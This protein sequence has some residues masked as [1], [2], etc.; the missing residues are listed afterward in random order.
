M[1]C[2][3]RDGAG[4]RVSGELIRDSVRELRDALL[5]GGELPQAF[6]LDLSGLADIDA[7]GIQLLASFLRSFPAARL[8][9]PNQKTLA[10]CARLGAARLLFGM[11]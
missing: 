4:A 10:A 6:E 9:N 7:A 11:P 8:S 2:L 1:I 3:T 5:A